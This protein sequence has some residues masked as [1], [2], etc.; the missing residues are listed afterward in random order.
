MGFYLKAVNNYLE[1]FKPNQFDPMQRKRLKMDLLGLYALYSLYTINVAT[2]NKAIVRAIDTNTPLTYVEANS[3]QKPTDMEVDE[4]KSKFQYL[5]GIDIIT[6]SDENNFYKYR[7]NLSDEIDRLHSEKKFTWDMQVK[8]GGI[9]E[10]LHNAT[11]HYSEEKNK[12]TKFSEIYYSGDDIYTQTLGD[13]SFI[14]P[15]GKNIS[16]LEP[17]EIISKNSGRLT[18]KQKTHIRNKNVSHY[19]IQDSID[20]G[21]V[22][23]KILT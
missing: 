1:P 12:D 8:L 13:V 7:K 4:L 16:K 14:T 20:D 2:A 19:V 18:S 5:N 22:L 17:T 11:L 15:E 21:L 23:T 3:E 6:F 9:K 10:V